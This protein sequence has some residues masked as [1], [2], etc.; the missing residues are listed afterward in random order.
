MTSPSRSAPS[1]STRNQ[2]AS[3][4]DEFDLAPELVHL[5]HGSYGAVP[6]AVRREQERWRD[7]IERNPTGFF[8]NELPGLLRA[9]A[10]HV[11]RRFGGADNGWVFCENATAAVNGVLGSLALGPGDEILTTSHVYG[12]VAKAMRLWAERR[13]ARLTVAELP[14]F[15]EHDDHVVAAFA[16]AI[17]PATRLI[18]VDH[19]TSATA[20]ILPVQRI[21]AL[22]RQA[23]V[24][25]F[26]DGAHAPGQIAL[27]VPGLGADW[28]VGNAHKWLFTPR[29]CG[30]LWTA[31]ARQAD[32]FPAVLSHGTPDGYTSAFDWIGTRDVTPWLCFETGADV[33]DRFGGAE[34]IARNHDL[35]VEGANLLRETLGAT[36]SAPPTMQGAMAALALPKL[37]SDAEQAAAFRYALMR[38]HGVVA[39]IY[40]F[41]GRLWL[42]ISAQIYNTRSDYERCAEA[43]CVLFEDSALPNP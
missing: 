12:A 42:R 4:W 7:L 31:P 18:I 34:L 24:P 39:P 38:D 40:L 43:C 35:A 8:Q 13:G 3:A 9:M 1:Q 21:A 41:G 6:V 28:Y 17:R 19:I 33:H 10:G 15:L 26:V 22:A 25:V 11:A 30:V 16:A 2:P 5:N 27:D 20:A 23:G 36:P 32:T 29:G 37:C 14:V